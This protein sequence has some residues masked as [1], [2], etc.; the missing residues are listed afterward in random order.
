MTTSRSGRHASETGAGRD[1]EN[2]VRGLVKSRAP[3]LSL[4]VIG[5]VFI[6]LA[7]LVF[8]FAIPFCAED[9]YI[10]AR[11]CFDPAYRAAATS[12]VW[13]IGIAPGPEVLARTWSLLGDAGAVYAAW[14]ILPTLGYVAF[15]AYW[16][17]PFFTGSS[18]SGLETHLAAC[19]VLAARIWPVGYALAASLR[20]DTALLALCSSGG[21]WRWAVAGIGVLIVA[22]LTFAGHLLPQTITSK[23]LTYGIHPGAWG[24]LHPQGFGWETL[25]LIPALG[26][27]PLLPV[28]AALAFLITHVVLG[29]PQFW[30]YAVPPLAALGFAA[31]Q[32]ITRPRHLIAALILMVSFFGGQCDILHSRVLQEQELWA[33]GGDLAALHPKGTI[34]L[35]PAGM[36]PYQNPG[37]KVIDDV[38][39]L[40]PWMA[41]RRK[42]GNGW[43]T[44]A[45]ARYKPDWIVLRLR[46]Y[47]RPERWS[48]GETMPYY[49]KA[50]A[51]L[52]GYVVVYSPGAKRLG[53]KAVQISLK[54]SS[55]VILK[56]K[57]ELVHK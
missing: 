13:A 9:F 35:E 37:L 18:V 34:L 21:K 16:V 32:A 2:P 20:P 3:H 39:L 41:E 57:A 55:L 48:I 40:D 47:V 54:S 27:V 25:A 42:A 44:D 23:A 10:T 7:R 11:A 43:R 26:A 33:V 1:G 15:L 31:C 49:S 5:L 51:K 50:D 12:S 56:R 52:P 19:A 28:L 24:W 4:L 45:I 36:I 30:W 38:G 17:S 53:G 14:R 46:E 8:Y 6:L 29:T 22:N